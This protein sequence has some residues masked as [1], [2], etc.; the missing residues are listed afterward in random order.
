VRRISLWGL[1]TTATIAIVGCSTAA[2]QPQWGSDG[3]AG[4]DGG[5]L[6]ADG[7]GTTPDGSASISLQAYYQQL[8]IIGCQKTF[9]CCLGGGDDPTIAQNWRGNVTTRAGCVNATIPSALA[10]DESG[11]ESAIAGQTVVYHP[12]YAQACL[13]ATAALSCDHFFDDPELY[14]PA[15][16]VSLFEGKLALGATCTISTQ[17][18]VG[19]GC[20][21]PLAGPYTCQTIPQQGQSCTG[22]C[23]AHLYCNEATSPP[24][25]VPQ[26]P[27]GSACDAS[28]LQCQGICDVPDDTCGPPLA[29]ACEGTAMCTPGATQCSG[30]SVQTCGA[31]ASW[32]APSAC[33]NQACVNGACTG[34]CTPGATECSGDA[35]QT[36]DATGNW[37]TPSTCAGRACVNGACTGTCTPGS[38]QCY[39]NA[40]QTCDASGTWVTTSPC[41]NQACVSGA[42]TG[43][44][45]PGATQCSNNAVETCDGTGNW[46]T[47]TACQ[48]SACVGGFCT[49]VCTPGDVSCSGAQ[50]EQCSSTGAWQNMGAA[51]AQPTPDCN[52]GSCACLGTMCSGTCVDTLTDGNNCGGCGHSCQGGTCSGGLCPAIALATGQNG[53]GGIAI[54]GSNVYWTDAYA[55]SVMDVSKGGGTP[56][57][58]S[59]AS[60]P[61]SIAV[62]GGNAY[63][64]G[65]GSSVESIPTS[66]GTVTT[67]SSVID[68]SS[69]AVDASGIYWADYGTIKSLPLG[70]GT[71]QSLAA[72]Q[73]GSTLYLTLGS[74]AVYWV[75]YD[76]GTVNATPKTGG[77]TTT[78][79]TGPTYTNSITT[80]AANVYWTNWMSGTLMSMPLGGGTITTLASGQGGPGGVTVDGT[81]IYWSNSGSGTVL[82]MPL[83]G[84]PILTLASGQNV[85]T[86]IA[87]DATTVYW[88]D[89]AAN[90]WTNGA[91]MKVAK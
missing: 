35:V 69:I 67:L 78:L 59:Y 2:S 21:G 8:A 19:D 57:L 74:N 75:D 89:D 63:W 85:P 30:N 5:G 65:N 26:L 39:A 42:C 46:G 50:P 37:G 54:D 48:S 84:G 15:P 41:T 13:T 10:T 52:Q 29:K 34:V 49:G 12:Q 44:C 33:T 88:I 56:N 90:N 66:G 70:G 55:S 32:G 61:G 9:D 31:G 68:A 91:V 72:S 64:T 83:A 71:A 45:T 4:A 38:V 18:G 6:G 25:C 7:G 53:A 28:Q 87:V 27:Q 82:E 86:A 1:A 36:C 51:C 24:T 80:D 22:Y 14:T 20:I 16:C 76:H 40:A 23:P 60:F 47:P 43:S 79:T 17:C 62:Y 58:L 77:T 11:V 81:N 73:S 3:D